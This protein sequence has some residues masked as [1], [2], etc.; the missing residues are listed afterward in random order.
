MFCKFICLILLDTLEENLFYSEQ[1]D[2]EL[3]ACSLRIGKKVANFVY[4]MA[5]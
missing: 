2:F 4:I 1:D 5:I 3:I